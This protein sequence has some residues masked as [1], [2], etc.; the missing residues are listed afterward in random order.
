MDLKVEQFTNI[1]A[2]FDEV[3]FVIGANGY[4]TV[5]PISTT[6]TIT[7]N[8]ATAPYDGES[9][10]VE[11][12]TASA[13]SALY[14]VENDVKY[15]DE[16]APSAERTD[17]GT[18]NM[19]LSPEKFSNTN[20]NF[21]NV[22]FEIEDG[23]MA[24]TPIAA[25]VT[26]I[27]HTGTFTYDG[28]EHTVNGYDVTFDDDD[29]GLYN[30]ECFELITEGSDSVSLTDAGIQQMNLGQDSFRNISP[31]F[32][33]VTF[34][35][36]DGWIT[37]DPAI[38][39]SKE[40][41][42]VLAVDPEPFTFNLTLTDD[43]GAAIVGHT[44]KA[45]EG[46]VPAL[47]TDEDGKASVTISV[48]GGQ[49]DSV[50]LDIPNEASLTVEEDKTDDP[51]NYKTTVNGES[52]ASETLE[53]W[54]ANTATLAFV[55]AVG[56]ICRIGEEEFQT[57]A[58]AIEWAQRNSETDITIEM[59]VDYTM[60]HSDEAVIPN[61]YTVT[62]STAS[63]YEGEGA[64]VITRTSDFTG[65]M[66]VNHGTLN[67]ADA[68]PGT[69]IAIDGNS[70]E[71]ASA[72]IENTGVVNVCAG[73]V[74]RNAVSTGNGGAIN[75]TG[76]VNVSGGTLQ[77]N[78][79]SN[80]G[81]V[82]STGAVSVVSGTVSGNTAT[83]GNGGAIYVTSGN[84][85][86]SGGEIR[87]NA[88][89][90]GGGVYA[91]SGA[92]TISGGTMAG[93]SAVAAG[94]QSDTGLGGALYIQSGTVNVTGG[95]IG[96]TETADANTAVNGS[97]IFVESGSASFTGGLI[98]GNTASEEGGAVGVGDESVTLNFSGLP[99]IIGNDHNVCLNV[100]SPLIINANG[101]VVS[102]N[103][104]EG[105]SIGIFVPGN[106]E[107]YQN[108]GVSKARFGR[109]TN[110]E[111]IG[112]FSNDRTPGMMVSEDN[113]W[114]QWGKGLTVETRYL[115][116]F[117]SNNLPPA[118]RGT[119][120]NIRT[121]SNY[122]PPALQN[123]VSDIATDSAIARSQ[124]SAVFAVAYADGAQSFGEC[125]TMV[126]W[127][128]VA[129]TWAFIR[130]DGTSIADVDKLILYFSEPSYISVE[131]NTPFELNITDLTVNGISARD[132]FGFVVA[133]NGATVDH[134]VPMADDDFT[135][136]S[137]KNIK[138]M[139]P[140]VL[141]QSYV[142]TGVFPDANDNIKYK[143]D[144]STDGT[145]RTTNS[146]TLTAT[147][148]TGEF[149]VTGKTFN[150]KASTIEVVFGKATDIC[151]I[152]ELNVDGTVKEEHTY[153]SLQAAV[154]NGAN[155][156]DDYKVGDTV[157]IE[158]LQDYLIKSGDKPDIPTGKNFTFTTAVQGQTKGELYYSPQD[159]DETNIR[160]KISRDQ[161]NGNSF[162]TI[163]TGGKDTTSGKDTMLTVENL[164]FDGK[165][166]GSGDGGVINGKS[167]TV[168]IDNCDFRN[169][170]ANNGGAVFIG[171][172]AG[173]PCVLS[174]TS[175]TFDNCTSKGTD[176]KGGGAIWT[177]AKTFTLTNSTFTNCIAYDQGGAVFHRIDSGYSY[178]TTSSTTVT[179]CT[180]EHCKAC[181]GGGLEIDSYT[182]SVSGCTF[183][184][185]QA[186][187]NG[188]KIGRNGG[189]FNAYLQDT[190]PDGQLTI[191][192]SSF[193]N[194]FSTQYGGGFRTMYQ[195]TI[196]NSQFTDNI[197]NGSGGGI[198]I[199]DEGSV[200]LDHCTVTGNKSG[201]SGGGV[202][203]QK[204][205]IT[206]RNGTTITG[207]SLTGATCSAVN[208]AGVYSASTVTI[209]P[210]N[211]SDDSV[212][213]KIIVRDN[214]LLNGD[215]SNLR[216]A[217][218]FIKVG[219]SGEKY[220][221][222]TGA[223]A[224][225]DTVLP[226]YT[227][228]NVLPFERKVVLRKADVTRTDTSVT[229]VASLSGAHFRIFRADLTEVT[230]GQPTG[231]NYYESGKSGVY[232]MGKLPFGT[233]YL[234]ETAA[235]TDTAYSGNLGKA[236]RLKVD[237]DADTATAGAT[238]DSDAVVKLNTTGND[239]AIAQAFRRYMTT[240]DETEAAGS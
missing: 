150:D 62:L 80:G 46:D 68:N 35:V 85:T 186:I 113:S 180:F 217:G 23:Y 41:K 10:T 61:G 224:S 184:D 77:N 117:T 64:A 188:N 203:C 195:T 234:V 45:A 27:G 38:V 226:V 123:Y 237:K 12:Y 158:M 176:R 74:I 67:I 227:V 84:V 161:G 48:A 116:S 88:A 215:P 56:N 15:E 232:F 96:G 200:I 214:T 104:D 213:D 139:F 240:G 125:L 221:A 28:T 25:T 147:A 47:V 63:D 57:I 81:A 112:A 160:A 114:L 223:V 13:E 183:F 2:N 148:A 174:V 122:Y 194:C 20:P 159:P 31:N 127:D 99:R 164:K 103:P 175:S 40:L 185:C 119:D 193:S 94:G 70:V 238:V 207:N 133:R 69:K 75:S 19:G 21:T 79:A 131:N 14:D 198:G 218:S 44:L 4:Q 36:T 33:K 210:A 189:G 138:L 60:P 202:Y 73:G 11:G 197:A 230:E 162:I 190:S 91:E 211:E 59:M 153:S 90:N 1:N 9:H 154:T 143:Y 54:T 168:T 126:N 124:A 239:D 105:A 199:T 132:G 49:T 86:V 165:Q 222:P 156:Y 140:G 145:K 151:K 6:V 216:L 231:R 100:D 201:T 181:A 110:T 129:G 83:T 101:L 171:A 87:G 130:R 146:A 17:A 236:F 7:G 32:D 235:P 16:D 106:S 24:I 136:A 137:E 50:T 42:N 93:N 34:E 39:I 149:S 191:S 118:N 3:T 172:T 204:K 52:K 187:P 170:E 155:N 173:D 205:E 107:L 26:I 167:C 209:G 5:N 225:G 182:A 51:N 53:N 142:L 30:E 128:S 109:Y 89:V 55:N 233:Y 135:L 192:D 228:M 141:K 120:A 65:P 43:A 179:G 98:T 102:D 115:A 206:L 212:A 152:V 95:A 144:T 97:A 219:E 220:T 71:A 108:R 22:T 196:T 229:A 121:T 157:K 66:F 134:F 177:S 163:K 18:T 111:G 37:V 208:G 8:N 92:M 76:T 82:Y 78:T 166:V 29:S 58:T 178:K 169:F 72:I